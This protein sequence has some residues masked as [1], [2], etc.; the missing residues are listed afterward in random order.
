MKIGIIITDDLAESGGGYSYKKTFFNF[1]LDQNL[2]IGNHEF[3]PIILYK[4]NYNK[5]IKNNFNNIDLSF[6]FPRFIHRSKNFLIQS[7]FDIFF[8][9]LIN[10][11]EYF[12]QYFYYKKLN[13]L[14][15]IFY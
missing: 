3:I 9:F 12:Y 5:L 11:L 2:I 6:S 14:Y 15:L 8:I 4:K 13:K 1:L 7:K 10:Y